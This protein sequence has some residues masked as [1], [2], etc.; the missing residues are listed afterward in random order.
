MNYWPRLDALLFSRACWMEGPHLRAPLTWVFAKSESEE[1]HRV[2]CCSPSSSR[3]TSSPHRTRALQPRPSLRT[4]WPPLTEVLRQLMRTP[5]F[6]ISQSCQWRR[7]AQWMATGHGHSVIRR[8]LDAGVGGVAGAG[9][10]GT[11]MPRKRE[12]TIRRLPRHHHR[13]HLHQTQR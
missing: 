9:G 6:A 2:L 4:H 1:D 11:A 13:R 5:T 12:G 10:E 7:A 8:R 3:R